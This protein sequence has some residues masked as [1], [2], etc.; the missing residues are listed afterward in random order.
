MPDTAQPLTLEDMPAFLP[1]GIADK[2]RF[3]ASV[4]PDHPAMMKDDQVITYGQF[5]T[6]VDRIA[7]SLQRDGVVLADD[8]A[9][10]APGRRGAR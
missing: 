10:N 7:A 5:D 9:P 2:V 8:I 3:V 1:G 4:R 6:M